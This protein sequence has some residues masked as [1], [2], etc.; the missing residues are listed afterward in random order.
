MR[1]AGDPEL[2]KNNDNWRAYCGLI[3]DTT[4]YIAVCMGTENSDKKFSGSVG[5]CGSASGISPEDI[6]SSINSADEEL[7]GSCLRG[8]SCSIRQRCFQESY[9]SKFLLFRLSDC[10]RLP[11]SPCFLPAVTTEGVLRKELRSICQG[12]SE[13]S[14]RYLSIY[15]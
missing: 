8:P 6:N 2:T 4:E 10:T 7:E 12:H 9:G 1:I 3:Q 11:S 14:N 5:K 15:R 13:I